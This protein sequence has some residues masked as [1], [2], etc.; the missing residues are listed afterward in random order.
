MRL[1]H[2]SEIFQGK[3]PSKI[4]LKRYH[5]II[6]AREDLITFSN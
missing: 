1:H 2:V 6:R 4:R 3:M 5:K